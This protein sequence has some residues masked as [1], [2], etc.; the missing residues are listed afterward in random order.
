MIYSLNYA[1]RE[2]CGR[3][4]LKVK[5]ELIARV[6]EYDVLTDKLQATLSWIAVAIL[7]IV[8]AAWPT[9]IANYVVNPALYG[10][11]GIGSSLLFTVLA[12]LAGYAAY[13]LPRTAT[14]AKSRSSKRVSQRGKSKI[15]AACFTVSLAVLAYLVFALTTLF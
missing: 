9:T 7:I 6:V 13:T 3:V 8:L 10:V 5:K 12:L 15:V 2:L 1:H 11:A 14:P 4:V